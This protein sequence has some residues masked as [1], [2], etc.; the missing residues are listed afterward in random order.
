LRRDWRAK[1]THDALLAIAKRR[2]RAP[3]SI[4]GGNDAEYDE[5]KESTGILLGW[6]SY[7]C[8]VFVEQVANTERGGNDSIRGLAWNK[9]EP[10]SPMHIRVYYARQEHQ[11]APE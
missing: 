3:Q 8:R 4:S 6:G 1:A 5:G 9:V 2:G 11:A 10:C 7:N